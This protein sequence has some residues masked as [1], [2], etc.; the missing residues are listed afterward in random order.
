MTLEELEIGREAVI[1]KVGGEGPLRC[2]FL[3]MGLIPKTKV[4]VRKVAPMGDPIELRIR[5][6]ELTIR[7]EDA[8][9]IEVEPEEN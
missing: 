8:G 6:Y 2:R 4:Q 9:K 1:T 5:G 7:K 3:D